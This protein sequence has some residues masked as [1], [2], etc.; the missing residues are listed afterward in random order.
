MK[1]VLVAI[2][3]ALLASGRTRL[4]GQAPDSGRVSPDTSTVRTFGGFVDTY[5][6]WDFDRPASFDR[7]FTTQP[8]RQAEANVN[9]AFVEAKW[10]GPRYRGRLALQWGTSVQANYAA[11]PRIG[12]VSGPS[13]S[14]FIQEATAGYQLASSLWLDAG[15]FFAHAGYESWISRD[16]LAYSRSLV[17]DFS[18][19]YEAGAKMTW[20]ASP[21]LT[22]TFA[23]VNGW[24]DISNYNTPPAGG[25][26][27]D[28]TPTSK[29]T[30]TY[31][32]FVGNMAADSLPVQL[33][34]YHDVIAQYNPNAK[35]QL[36]GVYSL[37]TQGHTI[38][39]DGTASWWGMAALAKYHATSKLAFVGRVEQYSDPSQV[40]V[41]TGLPAG[42]QT[43]G[44]S[45]GV[46]VSL[47]APVLWRTE[48]R[49]FRSKSAVWPL[50][51]SGD[52][53]RND[54]FLVTSLALSF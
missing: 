52:F 43:T 5:Y 54:G 53:G 23:L 18:P 21:K 12:A 27:F 7:A 22:A 28:Y 47:Q 50:H 4:A 24:Q 39:A 44:G 35:W 38:G 46:D 40:I 17:A 32:N 31:D 41:V 14:Q 30:L 48:L 29:V 49:G 45:F 15:I 9:L 13:V 19:Y 36:A 33:R 51:T 11:E 20:A 42:F 34:V 3:A 16:N 10:S 26:R 25:V 2:V 6:A 37:G 8:V 1:T